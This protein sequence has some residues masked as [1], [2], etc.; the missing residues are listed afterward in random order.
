MH[1]TSETSEKVADTVCAVE[2]KLC[3]KRLRLGTLNMGRS[4]SRRKRTLHKCIDRLC[5]NKNFNI[6]FS[7][8]FEMHRVLLHI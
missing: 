1:R 5:L 7:T 2:R 3:R 4:E 8:K 6:N